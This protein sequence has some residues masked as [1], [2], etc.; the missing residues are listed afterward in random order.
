LQPGSPCIDAGD[1]NSVP[2]DTNDLDGDGNTTEPIPFDL[3]GRPRITDGDCNDSN[4][5]DMGAYEFAWVYIGD[6]D[7]EC[8]V[9]FEDWALFAMA[10]L[11]EQGEAGYISDYDIS[12]PADNKVDWRDVEILRDNWLAHPEP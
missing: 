9:D 3:D 12:I 2:T 6:F 11:T 8:D 7:G 5:V 10:W 1:N 4:V